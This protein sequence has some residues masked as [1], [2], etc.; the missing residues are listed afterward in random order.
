MLAVVRILVQ[1]APFHPEILDSLSGIG[2]RMLALIE[3]FQRIGEIDPALRPATVARLIFAA[4]VSH[5]LARVFVR[6]HEDDEPRSIDETVQVLVRGL[7][8]A[9]DTQ[10]RDPT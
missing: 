1:E 2:S 8:P 6:L 10:R 4:I 7:A 3:R 9:H 5:L